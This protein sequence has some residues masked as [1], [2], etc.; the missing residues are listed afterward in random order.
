[1]LNGLQ[2][3][4]QMKRE[5]AFAVNDFTESKAAKIQSAINR[6]YLYIAGTFRWSQLEHAD[7]SGLRH[8][9]DAVLNTLVGG[10]PEAPMPVAMG[11]LIALHH[12]G[13]RREQLEPRSL[14]EF[15]QQ[16]PISASSTGRPTLYTKIGDTAQFRRL[17]DFDQLI[18]YS[19]TS[20]NDA[21]TVRVYFRLPQAQIGQPNW[22]DVAGPFLPG[23]L[24][25]QGARFDPGYVVER[26]VL[27]P[28]WT[29]SFTI[30]DTSSTLLVDIQ[31]IEEPGSASNNTEVS[32][33]RQLLRFWPTPDI[34]YPLTVTWLRD[35]Q[36]LTEDEDTPLMPVSRA[37]VEGAIADILTQKGEVDLAAR[38]EGLF[39]QYAQTAAGMQQ[40]NE[41]PHVVPRNRNMKWGAGIW[42]YNN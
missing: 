36:S 29:G 24:L 22:Q 25:A 18:A 39:V 8:Y 27:P 9:S 10:E 34:N 38:H 35:V 4:S 12:Q 42:H 7:E 17:A 28:T 14:K 21:L 41:T 33:T 16:S 19:D 32:Y 20:A 13:G 23:V 31:R 3:L 5:V 15:Y 30:L 40:S 6:R 37:L 26:V 2:T 11:R 1:M